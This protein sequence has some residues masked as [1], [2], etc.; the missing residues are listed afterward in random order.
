MRDIKLPLL[1]TVP[2][3]IVLL[4]LIWYLRSRVDSKKS[5]TKK[6]N[7]VS[8][9]EDI[10]Q[11]VQTSKAV[12]KEA[13][14]IAAAEETKATEVKLPYNVCRDR[15]SSA[16]VGSGDAGIGELSVKENEPVNQASSGHGDI[17]IPAKDKSSEKMIKMLKKGGFVEP[18][19][20]KVSVVPIEKTSSVEGRVQEE[21]LRADAVSFV[22]AA[23]VEA[24]ETFVMD[25]QERL[26]SKCVSQ[27]KSVV[28]NSL[29]KSSVDLQTN[30]V[31][32]KI[33]THKKLSGGDNALFQTEDNNCSKLSSLNDSNMNESDYCT[34]TSVLGEDISKREGDSADNVLFSESN[35][36]TAPVTVDTNISKDTV[37]SS[38]LCSPDSAIS[39]QRSN[40]DSYA[41]NTSVSITSPDTNTVT[42]EENQN[43]PKDVKEGSPSKSAS[44]ALDSQSEG[45]NDTNDSGNGTSDHEAQNQFGDA[46]TQFDFNM[47]SELCGRFIGKAGKNINHLK[48]KTGAN[49]S[50]TYNPFTPEFQICQVAGTQSE[51]DDALCMIRRKFP[52]KD[53]PH[54]TMMQVNQA[55]S[56]VATDPHP[57]IVPD[58]MQL[59]IPEGVSVEVYVS[60]VVDA[61][62]VF[63]QQ[64][65][66][67]S[68]MSL[69]KLNYFLNTTYSQDPNIPSVPTPLECGVICVCENEGAW[70]RAMI[71]SQTD[72]AGECQIKFVDY[73]GYAQ[74]NVVDLK[75]IRQDFMSLPF[76][77]VECTMANITILED[78][79]YYSE[80]ASMG[81]CEMTTGKLL[82]CQVVARNEAG[83]PHIHLYSIDPVDVTPVLINRALVN[84]GHVRW[85]ELC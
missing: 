11:T 22:Q 5:R 44:P 8:K 29:S 85:V 77:A 78:E 21:V 19:P 74:M 58:V 17:P 25:R 38:V 67:R 57:V 24:S 62:Q 76:Q 80:A 45:S 4:G 73:G 82:Q 20:V 39:E 69:E 47:P 61:G 36:S 32:E 1:L 16:L 28:E 18:K 79:E 10:K 81:L 42:S 35:D 75:Q 3:G 48:V 2:T 50:L 9:E 59:S 65:T 15:G 70:Y 68:F 12:E 52:L 46:K 33:V 54:M 26:E 56:A 72:E 49:V 23:P 66:H 14:R 27:E 43:A 13:A 63:I 37:I 30:Q 40:D 53:C 7:D 71:M 55:T 64:P 31:S 83:M 60:A 84:T 51:I 41:K 34:D 6:T